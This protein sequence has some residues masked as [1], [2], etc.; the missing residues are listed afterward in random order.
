M[1]L[2]TASV[3]TVL[4][5]IPITAG[6]TGVS[7]TTGFLTGWGNDTWGAGDWGGGSNT[8]TGSSWS[9]YCAKNCCGYWML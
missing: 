3:G 4:P 2:A 5:K 7:A 6:V 9:R 1:Y 8:M